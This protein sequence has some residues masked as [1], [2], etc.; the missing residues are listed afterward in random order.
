MKLK[1]RTNQ[2]VEGDELENLKVNGDLEVAEDSEV[3]VFE[4][5]VDKDGHKRFIEGDITLNEIAGLTNLYGKWSLSGSHLILVLCLKCDENASVSDN[6][7]LCTI[8]VPEWVLAKITTIVGGS[9]AFSI[10]YAYASDY[11][12]QQL[13]SRLV[14]PSTLQIRNDGAWSLSKERVVRIAYDLLI[15]NESEE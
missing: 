8:N 11:T 9:V 5:I 4:N 10:D 2:P 6:T 3:K 1:T 7:T 15:D 14:K 12:N 13:Q